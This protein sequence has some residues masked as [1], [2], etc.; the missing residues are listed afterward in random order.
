MRPRIIDRYFTILNDELDYPAEILL[1]G[2]AAGSLFGYIR[3]SLDVDFEIRIKGKKKDETL[4]HEAIKKASTKSGI[5]ANY[6]GDISHWSMISFLDYRNHTLPYKKLG[7]LEIK[8]IAPEYWTIGKMARFLELDIRD[9]VKV[10]RKRKLSPN[11]LARLWGRAMEASSLSL[12]SW[13]FRDHVIY[14]FD[15]YG[16]RVWGKKF[17]PLC[18]ISLFKRSGSIL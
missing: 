12:A 1:T 10:I 2:A 17:D 5:A 15:R 11:Q 14:F 6:S 7:R 16:K 9:M 3:P 18:A 4:I 8:L 13:Q